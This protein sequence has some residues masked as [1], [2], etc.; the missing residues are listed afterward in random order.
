MVILSILDKESHLDKTA[1]VIGATGLVGQALVDHL[2]E[3]D[4]IC[5][6]ITL[7]RTP[8]KHPSPKVFNQVV[9]FEHLEDYAE[10]FNADLLFSC[11]G[12]TLKQA[13]SLA[14]QRKVDLDYQFKAAQI[15]VNNGVEHYL[16]V[17]SSGANEESNSPYLKMKG[18]L[19]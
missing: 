2:A 17:S 4:H 9:D 7:T 5:K 16:L 11:L 6:I 13:G 1:I 14:A 15:A 8:A 12:T 3:A 19:E 18:V 10:S